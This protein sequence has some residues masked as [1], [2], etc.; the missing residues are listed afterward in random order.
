MSAETT[1][2]LD[3]YGRDER[4]DEVLG[5]YFLAQEQGTPQTPAE[6][7]ERHPDLADDLERFFSRVT[8]DRNDVI[9]MLNAS[10]WRQRLLRDHPVG[11]ELLADTQDNMTPI[12]R[13]PV[14]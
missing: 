11:R 8:I 12:G 2:N 9:H 5:N 4:L 7:Y 1:D 6:L 13:R 3:V 10:Q 14:R